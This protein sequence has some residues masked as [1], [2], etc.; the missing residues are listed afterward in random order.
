MCSQAN[1]PSCKDTTRQ[2]V[3]LDSAILYLCTQTFPRYQ[4]PQKQKNKEI[5][6]NSAR[7]FA[8]NQKDLVFKRVVELIHAKQK[9]KQNKKHVKRQRALRANGRSEGENESER[10]KESQS[11]MSI[12]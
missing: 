3:A 1:L 9:Q 2:I 10:A 7:N 8:N 11:I 12:F 4:S 6:R 5:N